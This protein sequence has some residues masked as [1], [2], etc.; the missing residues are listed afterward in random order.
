MSALIQTAAMAGAALAAVLAIV[1]LA[2]RGAR[3][4]R[5]VQPA[6][7][8]RLVLGETLALDRTR[9]LQLV[10]CDGREF[11]LLIGSGSEQVVSW[12]PPTVATLGT[13]P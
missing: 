2:G 8:R 12:L 6:T 5:L 11:L 3:M 10:S 7:G 9:R 4:L 1:V 13:G